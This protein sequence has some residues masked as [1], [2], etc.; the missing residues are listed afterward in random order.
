VNVSR[1]PSREPFDKFFRVGGDQPFDGIHEHVNIG[2][3]LTNSQCE[4]TG[5]KFLVVPSHSRRRAGSVQRVHKMS[6]LGIE[7]RA[8][9]PHGSVALRSHAARP[10]C[11]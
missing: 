8:F 6:G 2:A 10:H 11:L 4:V 3:Q 5:R 9:E 7:I 1:K